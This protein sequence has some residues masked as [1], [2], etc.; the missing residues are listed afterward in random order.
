[1][2]QSVDM[3]SQPLLILLLMPRQ[4]LKTFRPKNGV[5]G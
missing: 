4:I 1:M 2:D 3:S 5:G